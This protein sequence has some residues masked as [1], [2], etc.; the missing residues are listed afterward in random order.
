MKSIVLKKILIVT[1]SIL[2]FI[3]I[4]AEATTG[5][6][7]IEEYKEYDS[8]MKRYA[9]HSSELLY[10]MSVSYDSN[11]H[12]FKENLEQYKEAFKGTFTGEM[13]H[14]FLDLD[15]A[16]N[17][18]MSK[19]VAFFATAADLTSELF[20]KIKD[21]FGTKSYDDVGFT[22][23]TDTIYAPDGMAFVVKQTGLEL[24]RYLSVSSTGS[25]GYIDVKFRGVN[26]FLS[27]LATLNYNAASDENKR[28][29]QRY[30]ANKGDF[31]RF[32]DM[33]LGFGQPEIKLISL[34]DNK[35]RP[36]YNISYPSG[37]SDTVDNIVNNIHNYPQDYTPT[38]QPQLVCPSGKI[39]LDYVNGQ[40]KTVDN[41]VIALAT[42]ETTTYNGSTCNLDFDFPEIYY[43]EGS[44]KLIVGGEELT[45]T[46]PVPPM[47]MGILE[48]IRNSYDFAISAIDTAVIG[49]ESIG[50][51]VIALG[52]FVGSVFV[53][54]PQQ[55]TTFIM[56]A[57]VLAAGLWV[58]KR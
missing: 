27:Q 21:F 18:L 47:D 16:S 45:P 24:A 11:K 58:I 1:L 32:Y 3:P 53:F 36:V 26:G 44:N 19:P 49:L 37:L 51:S 5:T 25:Y 9:E 15:E 10:L 54:L 41:E 43:H 8:F 48:Y 23:V 57:F 4:R 2:L 13:I 6:T 34:S 52:T 42:D 14:Q 12:Y 20:G 35:E 50:G 40:F 55:M 38:V 33:W 30:D 39:K 29:V 56:A 17:G 31:Q 22:S 7:N 28:L 46:L